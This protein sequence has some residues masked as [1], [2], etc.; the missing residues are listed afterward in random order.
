MQP[1][2]DKL[3]SWVFTFDEGDPY[4]ME[5][6]ETLSAVVMV[7]CMLKLTDSRCIKKVERVLN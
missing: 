5:S 1:P 7:V 4:Y 2:N 6:S 3:Y